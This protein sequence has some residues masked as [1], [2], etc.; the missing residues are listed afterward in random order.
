MQHSSSTIITVMPLNK[1]LKCL[2][3]RPLIYINNQISSL[4]RH[5]NH[6]MKTKSLVEDPGVSITNKICSR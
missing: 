6:N 5:R 4:S 1:G 3:A 2:N